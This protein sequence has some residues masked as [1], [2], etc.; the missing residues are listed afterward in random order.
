MTNCKEVPICKFITPVV[1]S[2]RQNISGS[3]ARTTPLELLSRGCA[4]LRVQVIYTRNTKGG[5][6]PTAGED[7]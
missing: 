4:K 1:G 2:E 3:F 5:A 6:T 7:A